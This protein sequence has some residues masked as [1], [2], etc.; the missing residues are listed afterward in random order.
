MGLEVWK[1]HTL[2]PA[3]FLIFKETPEKI[4]M[5]GGCIPLM[6]FLR[7]AFVVVV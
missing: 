4:F 3:I 1:I 5:R 6:H 7:T 2:S